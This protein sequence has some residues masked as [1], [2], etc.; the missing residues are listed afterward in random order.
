MKQVT[1]PLRY[2]PTPLI[3][4]GSHANHDCQYLEYQRI[5][6]VPSLHALLVQLSGRFNS[7]GVDLS[8]EL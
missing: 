8:G 4:L 7:P 5:T 3:S 6:G 2:L 1:Q